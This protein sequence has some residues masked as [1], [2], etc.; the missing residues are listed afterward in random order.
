M[1]A[2]CQSP[3]QAIIP[4]QGNGVVNQHLPGQSMTPPPP[5][6]NHTSHAGSLSAG[7]TPRSVSPF[8]QETSGDTSSSVGDNTGLKITMNALQDVI[9]KLQDTNLWRKEL[10][11]TFQ[12]D[13]KLPL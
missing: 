9:N 13:F 8:S 7:S 11:R 1:P 4:T 12:E 5:P 3:V 2:Q 10:Q 6:G